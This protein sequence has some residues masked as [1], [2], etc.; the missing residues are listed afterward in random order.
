MHKIFEKKSKAKNFPELME[1]I[2]TNPTRT[3]GVS[4]TNPNQNK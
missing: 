3:D 2:P 1:D 4:P